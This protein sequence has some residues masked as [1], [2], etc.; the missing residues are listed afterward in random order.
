[1]EKLTIFEIPALYR[2]D[3]RITGYR[4]GKGEK[5]VVIVGS[6]RGNE[7]QQIYMCSMLVKRLKE[8]EQQGKLDE[9]KEIL[10]IPS[11]NPYSMNIG[12]RF[13]PTDNTDINR[14]FPGYALGETTQRIAAGVFEQV[15]EYPV[16][17]QF[18]SFY[19]PGIYIPHVHIMDTGVEN[20]ELGKRF[21]LPFVILRSPRPYDTT[22]LNY[23]WQIWEAEAYSLYSAT[24]DSLDDGTGYQVVESV[25]RFLEVTGILKDASISE[26]EDSVLL[27]DANMRSLR[28]KKAGIFRPFV[29]VGA[30]VEKGQPVAMILDAYEGEMIETITA[31][32]E[33]C[34]FFMHG[35]PMTY[36]NTAVCK[37]IVKQ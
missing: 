13:W 30:Y 19:M 9:T 12:K 21:G 4:F 34:V 2:D 1:M 11:L 17:I 6:L 25:F 18:A 7:Y 32:E 36:A 8:Y 14:M 35:S 26:G 28:T 31:P 16:G 23:N 33:G 20:A 24:T 5:S 29:T 15:S 22:T 37:L 10:V 27:T 3:F